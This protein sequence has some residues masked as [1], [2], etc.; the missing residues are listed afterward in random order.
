MIRL[1]KKIILN[2]KQEFDEIKKE[3]NLFCMVSYTLIY[4]VYLYNLSVYKV[5]KKKKKLFRD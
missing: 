1:M 5:K 3:N 4:H 2:K